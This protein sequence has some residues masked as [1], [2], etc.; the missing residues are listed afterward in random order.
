M[1]ADT[2]N[3]LLNAYLSLPEWALA[4]ILVWT[5]V[6]KGI[7]LWKSSKKNSLAWFV[8][9]LVVNTLG[10][11]EILYIFLFSNIKSKKPV[12]SSRSSKRR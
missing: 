3:N 1:L 10:I 8:V 11:L 7:A 9:L 12:R 5:L 6:W 4:L 2:L